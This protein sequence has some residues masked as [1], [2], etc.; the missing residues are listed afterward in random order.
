M[1][2][3]D[4][5]NWG[6]S[7]SEPKPLL[8]GVTEVELDTLLHRINNCGFKSAYET[9]HKAVPKIYENVQSTDDIDLRAVQLF[10][11]N[12]FYDK[13][14]ES[15]SLEDLI[16]HSK[17]LEFT[18]TDSDCEYIEQL[19]AE[20]S[21]SIY[22]YRFRAGRITASNFKKSCRTSLTNPSI[23]LIK[24]ICYPEDTIFYSKNTDYGCKHED[25]AF[26]QLNIEMQKVHQNY[27][28][29]KSGFIVTPEY[30]GFGASPDGISFCS[31]CGIQAIEIKCPSCMK[32][33]KTMMA[34]LSLKDRYVKLTPDGNFQV[35]PKHAYFY[36]MQMQMEL[37]N[38][39]NCMFV[40][41][42]PKDFKVIN[43]A[44]DREFWKTESDKAVQ[45]FQKVIIPEMMG[46]YFTNKTHLSN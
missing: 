13:S 29:Q 23:S 16:E 35:D 12:K 21:K 17:E 28:Q 19:S 46:K 31:C 22:W 45:F 33:G 9:L 18:V 20:Q 6:K 40:I 42:S 4:D 41:W 37:L 7:L 43:V 44:R 5:L 30:N 2:K 26:Q 25:D 8:T 24:T 15:F 27:Y 10:L 3:I 11:C 39:E 36:Q 1:V 34:L 32:D 38:C 14:F